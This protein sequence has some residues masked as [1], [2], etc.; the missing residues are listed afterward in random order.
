MRPA[1][2]VLLGVLF[3]V[4]VLISVHGISEYFVA[5]HHGWAGSLRSMI[6]RNY[7]DHGFFET[8]LKPYKHD[9]P[10]DELAGAPIH[11]NHPP[12]IN[13]AVGVSFWVFGESEAAARLPT[14]LATI[15]SF[16]FLFSIVRRR[17][18]EETALLTVAVFALLPLQVEYGKLM[19]YEV[20]IMALTLLAIEILDR[21]RL[22]EYD[23]REK[24]MLTAGVCAAMVAAGLVDWSAYFLAL[25]VGL[26]A[27]VRKPRKPWVF[28]GVGVATAL[29][30]V[31]TLAWLD[32]MASGGGL[33]QLAEKRA[34]GG[35]RYTVGALIDVTAERFVDYFGWLPLISAAGWL[36]LSDI[37]R[38]LDPVIF[39]FVAGNI[40]YMLMFK[41]AAHVH[42]FYIYYFTPAIAV[43]SALFVKWIAEMAAS[44][45]DSRRVFVTVVAVWSLA[46][47]ATIFPMYPRTHLRSYTILPPEKPSHGFPRDGFLARSL[48]GELI[49]SMTDEDDLVAFHRSMQP[50]IQWRFYMHRKH[51]IVRNLQPPRN[52]RLFVAVERAV[53]QKTQAQLAKKYA[54]TRTMGYLIYDLEKQGPDVT[55]LAFESRD[56][57]VLHWLFESSFYP[58]HDLVV[59]PQKAQQYL[60]KIGLGDTSNSPK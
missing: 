2:R 47:A 13:I 57:G 12:T 28:V 59:R 15:V 21:L 35:D 4:H 38:R 20:P 26:D 50:S 14:V 55:H 29:T 53:P 41:Q 46:F 40:M 36:A 7:V 52:A 17:H 45:F 39:I 43:A 56:P 8:G 23:D 51:R 34:G 18:G 19:N 30:L 31:A 3:V 60:R 42:N 22:G 10:R 33:M 5:G 1:H 9:A 6:A 58:P 37:K 44:R 32:S 48:A 16:L 27:L 11:W 24:R 25:F 54:L 49:R